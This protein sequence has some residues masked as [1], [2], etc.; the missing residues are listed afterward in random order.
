[1]GTDPAATAV[2]LTYRRP[3]LATEVVR[4]LIETERLPED[5]ILLVINGPVGLD[6]REL[7][8]R[9][10]V[11]RLP[12]NRGPAGGFARGLEHVRD[13]SEASWIYVC[14]DDAGRANLPSPR[15]SGL[16]E[17]VERFEREA[18]GLPVGAVVA[19]GWDI[20]RRTGL[21][22]RHPV[23]SPT[24]TFEEVAFGP[25]W[26]T[27]L[28]RRVLEAGVLP[29]ETLF[30]WAEDLDFFLRVRSA[31]FRV[32]VDVA[33]DRHRLTAVPDDSSI[34][35]PGRDDEPWRSYYVARNPFHLRRRHGGAT[36]TMWHLLKSARRYH[37]APTRAHRA[38]ILRG[39]GDG[40]RGRMGRNPAFIRDV[41]ERVRTGS[42]PP[43]DG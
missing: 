25:W 17:R 26:A 5:R 29:D 19:T 4:G 15:L 32:L 18:P 14:E 28:S 34:I 2:V 16:I 13:H 42:A 38:A 8:S 1:M 43:S 9:I 40:L 37:L 23:G 22:S 39:L 12:E 41:G 10:G 35:R 31:G 3:R 7:E 30:W 33:A 21:T 27:L 36:W 24:T 11:L 6:D 20:D